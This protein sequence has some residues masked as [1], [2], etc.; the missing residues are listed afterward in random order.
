MTHTAALFSACV[1]GLYGI[2]PGWAADSLVVRINAGSIRGAASERSPGVA[3]FRGIP[4]AASTAGENRWRPPQP[5]E[6]WEGVRDCTRFGPS[7]PQAPYPKD[8]VYYRDPEP[9][10]EDCLSLNIW[11]AGQKGDRKPVMVWIHGGALTRGSGAVEVYDGSKLARK[12]VVVVTINYRLGPLGFLAH[13]ELTAESPE[14]ASGNYGLLDQ[15]AALRWVRDNIEQFGGD[16]GCVTIFGESAGSLS[17]NAL[18]ASPLVKGLFHRA[19][20][21]S[22]TAFRRMA[23]QVDAEKQGVAFAKSVGAGNL[24][25][26]RA[27]AADQL[28][29]LAGKAGEIRGTINVDG[30]CLPDDVRAIFAAGRQNDVP[31]ITGSNADEMTTLAPVA[32]RPTTRKALRAQLALLLGNPDEVEKLY[33][34]A[35]DAAATAAFLDLMGDATFT[36]GA[37]SWARY[38]TQAG[39]KLFLY[40][41]ARVTPFAQAAGIGAFHAAEIAYVFDNLDRLGRPIEE[42]DRQLAE[43]MSTYWTNFARTGDPNGGALPS[44]PA[45]NAEN[46][47][48]LVFGDTIAVD[49]HLRKEKLD[50]LERL[51]EAQRVR[52]SAP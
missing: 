17:V 34:A 45:Y 35:D 22:G 40:Q 36:L 1:L 6:P 7:C 39:G 24:A 16:P 18:V 5:A 27:I 47:P 43:T 41:F 9:Q 38:A 49:H 28:I 20:G 3:V 2:S 48:C 11:T 31:T 14:Q 15:I 30:W 42:A 23:S 52:A 50:L 25:E 51:L 19:I 26:L 4:Y 21:Q 37:R 32:G 33:P 46:E 10:S 13:P 29:E 12:G 8:S 44:W